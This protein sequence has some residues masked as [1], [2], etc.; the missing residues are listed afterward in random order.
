MQSSG[1]NVLRVSIHILGHPGK[2]L[3]S[4]IGKLHRNTLSGQKRNI[5]LDKSISRLRKNTN[6]IVLLQRIQLNPNGETPLQ[7][8]DKVAGLRHME[9]SCRNK[10]N[11]VGLHR[12]ILR[13]NGAALDNRQNITLN[14]FTAHI[15]PAGA[16]LGRYLVNFVDEDNAA[17]LSLLNGHLDNIVHVDEFIGFLLPEDLPGLC[18]RDLLVFLFLRNK[19]AEHILQILAHAVEIRPGEHSHHLGHFLLLQ[20]HLDKLVLKLTLFQPFLHKGP[21]GAELSLRLLFRFFIIV[22]PAGK[23]IHHL[24]KGIGCRVVSL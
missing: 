5:L 6:E 12:T 4:I 16:A 1:T 13:S 23:S 15:C 7:L 18:H 20:L 11:M 17:L 19:L 14:A 10:E 8:R 21:A 3:D 24:C 22:N 2:P 9:G